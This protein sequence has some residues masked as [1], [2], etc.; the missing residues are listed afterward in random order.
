M[1]RN[2]QVLIIC[3]LAFL[4]LCDICAAETKDELNE[5]KC[6]ENA[7]AIVAENRSDVDRTGTFST[8][9]KA[10]RS[11]NPLVWYFIG[12]MQ[13]NS[14]GAKAN[15][16]E[17]IGWLKKAG[18]SGLA[19]AQSELAEYYLTGGGV[20]QKIDMKNA[21]YWLSKLA[22]NKN[23]RGSV[24]AAFR[25]CSI[26]LFGTNIEPDY[27]R[28]FTWCRISGIEHHNFEGLT[29]LALL[30]INGWGVQKNVPLAMDYYKTAARNNVI[31]AQLSL[32]RAYS[33]GLDVPID[34]NLAFEW[35]SKAA[36]QQSPIGM[37]YLAQMY[38]Y[39]QGTDQNEDKAREY[40]TKAAKLGE[41]RAQY[42]LGRI[43][44]YS[45]NSN[46]DYAAKWYHKAAAQGNTDAMIAIGDLYS[47]QNPGEMMRWYLTA[48]NHGNSDGKLRCIPFL[49]SGA[50]YVKPNPVLALSFAEQLAREGNSSGMYWLGMI[51]LKGYAGEKDLK[52]AY[53][54]LS[55]SA[56]EGNADASFELGKALI[57]GEFGFADEL[58][59]V[60]YLQAAAE[61][62]C[63]NDACMEL[64]RYYIGKEDFESA[65]LW[66]DN[67][68]DSVS[69]ENDEYSRLLQF[70]VKK[71]AEQKK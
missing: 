44:Q 40:Y 27:E 56:G 49:I 61:N 48:A 71:L 20:K 65:Y 54:A 26:Y 32:G 1:K 24:D 63:V 2:Q 36:Q 34:Y 22:T 18:E 7:T 62:G 64:I 15:L 19:S 69:L 43:F 8:C 59:G 55:A 57:R 12:Y 35:I 51:Y 17:G 45:V 11:D 68:K 60:G 53:E 52:A 28:A 29:N 47:K 37:Y 14:I 46:I 66:L 41:P 16:E 4:C 42:A 13:L 50:R 3:L 33:T 25:L 67:A 58:N 70:T 23:S 10:A 39:G 9:L 31:G 5:K 6:I 21:I 30:Y 38:E